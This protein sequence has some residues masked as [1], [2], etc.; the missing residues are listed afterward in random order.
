MSTPVHVLGISGSLRKGSL[1]TALLRN[2]AELLPPNVTL[3]IADISALPLY[4]EDLDVGEGPEPVRALRA[5]IAAADALLLGV[6]EYNYSFSA[7]IKN[8]L[9]WGS[10]PYRN[11][12]L[13][14]K[15]AAFVST[16]GQ[17]GGARAQLQL[18]QV[19]VYTNLLVLNKPEV[20]IAR[21]WEKFDA[22]GRLTDEAAR[23]ALR[24]QLEAL[25][26][27]TR[28]LRGE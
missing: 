16:G 2:A 28:R 12:P 11:P 17:A 8:V 14:G 3:D 19:A 9:D 15:P 7:A 5:Q 18:R 21:G 6:P 23:E 13:S 4:N 24:A 1:H 22:E 25:A 20:L 26:A 10:R 27:W